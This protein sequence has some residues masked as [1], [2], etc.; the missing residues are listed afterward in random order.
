M[1]NRRR[2][3]AAQAME[4]LLAIMNK[5]RDAAGGCPWDRAQTF[6]SV[7]PYTI[8]EAYEVA[9][10]IAKGDIAGLKDE[11]GDLLF[12]VVFHAQMAR[13]AKAFDFADVVQAIV[14][15]M[16]RRHPHVFGS[17]LVRDAVA[18]TAAWEQH[19]AAERAAQGAGPA[20]PASVL[21][22]VALALPATTRA[23]KLQD[24]AAR[25]GFDWP[26]VRSIM[27]KVEEHICELRQA[28]VTNASAETTADKLGDAWFA[29]ANVARRLGVDPESALRQAN[30]KF[31]RRF[32]RIEALLREAGKSVD[33]CDLAEMDA[34][35]ARVKREEADSRGLQSS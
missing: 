21:D 11:L 18:Q 32:R 23:I 13:E 16:V 25:T 35:W 2:T 33:Q 26:G 4:R 29:L 5:L 17:A 10:A 30:G 34:L 3:N 14:D 24:R 12:Q 1:T 9:D 19:K 8:E 6:D 22:A 28:I 20:A 31:E 27:A 15:K 7:A